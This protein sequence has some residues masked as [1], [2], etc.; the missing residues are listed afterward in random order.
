MSAPETWIPFLDTDGTELGRARVPA[1]P[2]DR[3]E[4]QLNGLGKLRFMVD[5]EILG[6]FR[7]GELRRIDPSDTTVDAAAARGAIALAEKREDERNRERNAE[8]LD[9]W[10]AADFA[11]LDAYDQADDDRPALDPDD[12]DHD[13]PD[14]VENWFRR[15]YR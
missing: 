8:I 11:D 1:N 7:F 3:Y 14:P 15:E 6:R 12:Y 13:P 2:H 5:G 9:T 10:P 4:I